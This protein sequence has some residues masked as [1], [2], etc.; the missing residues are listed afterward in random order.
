MSPYLSSDLHLAIFGLCMGLVGSV[1]VS[2]CAWYYLRRVRIERPPIGTFNGR[3]IGIL[4][5][6]LS[7]IPLFY[8]LLPRWLLTSFLAVTFLASISIGFGPVLRPTQLWLAIGSL[9]GLNIWMGNNL[10]GTALGWQMFWAENDIIIL[11]GAVSVANLYVQGGMKMRHVAWFALALA[12]Y[13][14]IFTTIWPVTNALVEEFLGYPLDPSMGM[15]WGFDNA[16]TGIGDLLVYALL[17]LTAFKAYG[18][19]AGQIAL[20]VVVTFGAVVPAFVPLLINYVDSRTDTLV[21]AQA[22]FGPAAYITYRIMRSRYGRERTMKEFEAS[23]DVVHPRVPIV[24][25]PASPAAIRAGAAIPTDSPISPAPTLERDS[26]VGSE[27]SNVV[28][29][30]S[31]AAG[32][33]HPR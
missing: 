33:G 12:G 16:A 15:R 5:V 14:M 11:L 23:A 26:M 1:L 6:L 13:D 3:D 8:L 10:L 17:V 27:S 2:V 32:A 7:T 30:D 24:G 18:R 19:R 25:P 28:N 29:S 9:I 22:W 31:A 21:P 4:F 20:A